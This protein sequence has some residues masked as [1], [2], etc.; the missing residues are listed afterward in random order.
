MQILKAEQGDVPSMLAMGDLY[1]YGAHGLA[2]DQAAAHRW[3][4]TAGSAPHN[5]PHGQVGVGNMLLKG[6]GLKKYY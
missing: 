2:R 5:N 1:Y 4:R 3:Y 6:E